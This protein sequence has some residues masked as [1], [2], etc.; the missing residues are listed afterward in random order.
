MN[1]IGMGLLFGCVFFVGVFV[2]WVK[3][4]V[5]FCIL[6]IWIEFFIGFGV[7]GVC[8]VFVFFDIGWL[9][10]GVECVGCVV[11]FVGVL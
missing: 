7:L 2:V 1:L 10:V 3:F 6:V 4:V 8:V 11:V 9:G 5:G